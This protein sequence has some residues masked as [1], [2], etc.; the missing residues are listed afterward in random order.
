ME[1]GPYKNKN[2]ARVLIQTLFKYTL[3]ISGEKNPARA[4]IPIRVIPGKINK[5]APV[6]TTII[7][8]KNLHSLD[9]KIEVTLKSVE[10]GMSGSAVEYSTGTNTKGVTDEA[11]HEATE[12]DHDG[13][14]DDFG[15]AADVGGPDA[16]A[17]HRQAGA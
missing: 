14:E 3:S 16:G 4:P 12:E 6:Y 2:S 13:L 15:G 1:S 11:R 7:Q 9:A 10:F 8:A 5:N 17:P